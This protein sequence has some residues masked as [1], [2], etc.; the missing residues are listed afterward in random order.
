MR[1]LMSSQSKFPCQYLLN[2]VADIMNH[3]LG[4]VRTGL[5]L[6]NGISDIDFLLGVVKKLKFDPFDDTYRAYMAENQLI[7][8]KV[9]LMSALGRQESR[10]SHFR[11]DFPESREE[12]RKASIVYWNG[13]NPRVSF[14]DVGEAR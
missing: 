12:F 13:G 9:I 8:A 2:Q 10:G 5:Q 3:D 7:L 4:I 14:V 1:A 11:S 6:Q